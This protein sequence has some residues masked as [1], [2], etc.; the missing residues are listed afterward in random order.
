MPCVRW[1]RC[2]LL[3]LLWGCDAA[4]SPAL[5]PLV[6]PDFSASTVTEVRAR[7]D[8]LTLWFDEVAR[9][10]LRGGVLQLTLNGRT[11]AN[12]ASASSFTA[13]AALGS[14][15]LTGPRR[16][17]VTLRNGQ[18]INTVLSGQPLFLSLGLHSGRQYGAT[19]G[20]ATQMTP[21]SG[22]VVVDPWLRPIY[23]R[24][25]GSVLRYRGLAQS[26]A[27]LTVVS[28]GG[29][30]PW[31][32]SLGVARYAFDWGGTGLASLLDSSTDRVVFGTSSSSQSSPL[33]LS[34]R[35]LGLD[36]GDPRTIWPTPRC[37]KTVH[38]CVNSF[39]TTTQDLSTCGLYQQVARCMGVDACDVVPPPTVT[40][41]LNARD[42]A[43]LL[44]PVKAAHDA[45][46]RTGGS[47]CSVTQAWAFTHPKC[48]A[49]APTLTEINEA[50]FAKTDGDF[51]PRFGASLTR[52]ALLATQT[53]RTGLLG[54]I[55]AFVGDTEV[56]ATQFDSEEPCHNC[57]QFSLKF[58]LYY[59]RKQTVIVVNGSYGYDS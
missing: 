43:A 24:E 42:S 8:G 35:E 58:V 38:D 30:H 52:A 39:P 27:P 23:Y 15:T 49:A 14:V 40:F 20:L 12:L 9:A 26:T 34:V 47:W 25:P 55:D 59:P 46:P 44:G 53:F 3:P 6:E 57:H 37:Q 16:F 2:L 7:A 56:Q 41:S 22:P 36:Q 28:L 45:C 13:D 54:S 19:L 5:D 33:A 32:G 48:L 11:S 31:V 50:A 17:Q 29:T 51:D 1:S 4:L 10:G 21:A 18:E